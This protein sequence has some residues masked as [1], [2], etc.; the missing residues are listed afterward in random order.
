[1]RRRCR[2]YIG[3]IM[4]S[5]VESHNRRMRVAGVRGG[6][7]GVARITVPAP[8]PAAGTGP[9]RERGDDRPRSTVERITTRPA[10]TT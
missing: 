1:M 2:G 7:Q 8:I 6:P 4:T 5:D 10:T 3:S 9:W